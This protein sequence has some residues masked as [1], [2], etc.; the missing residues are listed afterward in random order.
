MALSRD[1]LSKTFKKNRSIVSRK[2]ADEML[3]VPVRGH[4][5]DME[6][7][8]TLNP[9]AEHIWEKLDGKQNMEDL[10]NSLL[11]AF[12]VDKEQA[13]ADLSE[14][15]GELLDADLILEAE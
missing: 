1:V 12:D 10:R 11:D 6:R 4:L 7:I 5:A 9:V 8:F 13:E 2:I 15:I 3:L 14:F